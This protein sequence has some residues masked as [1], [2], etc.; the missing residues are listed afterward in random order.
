MWI[1]I[2][3]YIIIKFKFSTSAN[4]NLLNT[5]RK[6]SSWDQKIRLIYLC[7]EKILQKNEYR[8]FLFTNNIIDYFMSD[9][10]NSNSSKKFRNEFQWSFKHNLLY[11]YQP[12]YVQYAITFVTYSVLYQDFVLRDGFKNFYIIS[13]S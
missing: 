11:E 6:S 5:I 1:I 7:W 8:K 2:L 9:T 4:Y 13:E 3:N 12:I 10:F